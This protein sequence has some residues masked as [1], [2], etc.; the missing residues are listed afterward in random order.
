M[1][2]HDKITTVIAA[3][4]IPAWTAPWWLPSL[5]H[6]TKVAALIYSLLGIVW[7]GKKI[8]ARKPDES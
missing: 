4:S 8:L 3:T 6:T 2:S 5:D 1:I 7:L